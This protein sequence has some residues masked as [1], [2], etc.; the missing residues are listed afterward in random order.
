LGTLVA[1]TLLF[2]GCGSGIHLNPQC[3]FCGSINNYVYAANAAGKPSTASALASDPTSGKITSTAGSPYNDSGSGALAITKAPLGGPLYV[4]NN[5]SGNISAFTVDTSTG[6]LTMVAGS[7]FPAETGMDSIAIDPGGAFLYAVT[8]DSTN[9]W[10]YYISSSGVLTPLSNMPMAIPTAANGSSAV[11]LDPAGKYLY[12]MMQSNLASNVYG[13][14]RDP[15]SGTLT[16][17]SGFPKPLDGLANRAGSTSA[18]NFCWLLA[19]TCLEQQ[20]ELTSSASTARMER[21]RGMPAHRCRL[22]MILQR[23]LS[24]NS[25]NTCM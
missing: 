6:K 11:V 2:P 23:S 15:T 8:G 16:A 5:F 18:G 9:L 21:L 10:I 13:F 4:A 22:E 17:L 14:V 3:P 25:E 19:Q 12:V 7:P 20:V 24:T 1:F